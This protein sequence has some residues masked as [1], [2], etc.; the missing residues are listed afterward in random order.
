MKISLKRG[1]RWRRRGGEV[2]PSNEHEHDQ[3]ITKQTMV[4]RAAVELYTALKVAQWGGPYKRCPVCGSWDVGRA[5]A[6]T[7]EHQASCIIGMAIRKAEAS[8]SLTTIRRPRRS[9]KK[10]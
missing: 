8:P 1:Q 9:S 10:G 7:L 3:R 2:V 5:S 6:P 4:R